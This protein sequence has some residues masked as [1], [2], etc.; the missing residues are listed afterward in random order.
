MFCCHRCSSYMCNNIKNKLTIIIIYSSANVHATI[1]PSRLLLERSTY[2]PSNYNPG[3]RRSM[4]V[5]AYSTTHRSTLRSRPNSPQ[6]HSRLSTCRPS[7]RRDRPMTVAPRHVNIHEDKENENPAA[8]A[9][10]PGL[11]I[12]MNLCYKHPSYD[13]V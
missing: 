9:R 5:T 3:L 10:L 6:E 8:R 7:I 12:I 4:S 13:C 2:S 11:P 1:E